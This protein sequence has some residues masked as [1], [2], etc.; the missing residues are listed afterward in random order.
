[1]K[2]VFIG[3]LIAI[4]IVLVGLLIFQR[5]EES[6]VADVVEKLEYGLLVNYDNGL[7]A[8][9][10]SEAKIIDKDGNENT[11]ECINEGDRIEIIYDGKMQESYP[12]QINN[13]YK[14]K[15]F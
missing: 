13:V 8:V 5:E 12:V 1:M 7:A 9:N 3:I 6:I 11:L 4:I 14:I 10:T 2:K 15:L